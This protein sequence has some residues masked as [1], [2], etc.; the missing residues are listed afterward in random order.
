MRLSHTL[1]F[2]DETAEL[3]FSFS[4]LDAI[5][6]EFGDDWKQ[7]LGVLFTGESVK[8]LPFVV[9]CASGLD[10][11]WFEGKFPITPLINGLHAAF[12]LSWA[13]VDVSEDE[14]TPEKKPV[15]GLV[16]SLTPI[17]KRGLGRGGNTAVSGA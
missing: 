6:R 9:S 13:G 16:R 8:D 12:M 15:Q 17:W 2:G 7:R 5:E 3:T 10:A 4:C 1:K 11:E 14:K